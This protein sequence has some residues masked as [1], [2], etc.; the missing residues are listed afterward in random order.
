M[1]LGIR[2][3]PVL[4]LVLGARGTKK[5]IKRPIIKGRGS[6]GHGLA[7]SGQ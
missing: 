5:L 4:P 2:H 7:P 3:G 1:Q 6:F